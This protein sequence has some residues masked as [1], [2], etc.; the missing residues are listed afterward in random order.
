MIKFDFSPDLS[1]PLSEEKL[2]R[3][4]NTIHS[5]NIGFYRLPTDSLKNQVLADIESVFQRF[6]SRK[7]F[8]HVG[9]GGSSLG[10]EMLISAL[11]KNDRSFHFLN[12]ID[13]DYL[14]EQLQ[15]IDLCESVYFIVSK[16]GATAETLATMAIL[17]QKLLDRG[18]SVEQLKDYFVFATDP[19]EGQLRELA[20]KHSLA[21]LPIPQDIGGRFSVLTAVG[22]LP[23]R[24]AEIDIKALLQGAQEMSE[25]LLQESTTN[26]LHLTASSLFES[27]RNQQLNETV[28]MPYSSKLRDF[29]LW[30]V[31]LWA[32]SLGKK[33]NTMGQ[34]VFSGLTP[35]AA[36]GATDQH[37]QMQLFMHGVRNKF[38]ILIEVEQFNQDFKLESCFQTEGLNKL[39]PHSLAK[40]M[41][42][43][44]YGTRQALEKQGRPHLCLKLP[45][46][47]EKT[48]GELILFFEALTA[49]MGE[50]LDINAFDQ[51][52]VEDG[53]IF[54][55][56]W[57][58]KL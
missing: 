38:L 33:R 3:Y 47:N 12:N 49:L 36:Y 41:K 27:Y 30:F 26:P 8:V 21:T 53:K 28:L 5:Q 14:H 51:P 40:L 32:E 25:R 39:S 45:V 19:K 43:E 11:K 20:Q 44:L 24:F 17:S 56:E 15:K 1:V 7:H 37:S 35:I 4:N 52:G 29:S 48:L 18:V 57:L 58:N 54:A 42:A 6:K 13:P 31:Q 9:I 46:L 22:L 23:A 50:C 10:P 2:T 55:Y 34:E 16:S